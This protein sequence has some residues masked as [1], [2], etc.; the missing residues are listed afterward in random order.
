[1]ALVIDYVAFYLCTVRSRSTPY[2]PYLTV[3]RRETGTSANVFC[4]RVRSTVGSLYKH[5]YGAQCSGAYNE[6]VLM[7][8]LRVFGS[9]TP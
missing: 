7:L 4:R 5:E 1:M 8:K 3:R 6:I 2:L 9:D